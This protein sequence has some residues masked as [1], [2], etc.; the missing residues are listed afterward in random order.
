MFG[1]LNVNFK[2]LM[3]QCEIKNYSEQSEN[4]N[5]IS[6]TCDKIQK[7][8]FEEINSFHYKMEM[9]KIKS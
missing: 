9:L 6:K 1:N 4:E 2:K 5:T 7:P 8:C 3:D